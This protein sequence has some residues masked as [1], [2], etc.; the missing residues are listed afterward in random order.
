MATKILKQTGRHLLRD[1]GSC[2][3]E[4]SRMQIIF[5]IHAVGEALAARGRGFEYVAVVPGRSDARIQDL[6]QRCRAAGVPVRSVPRDQLTRLAPYSVRIGTHVVR[7]R[8]AVTVLIMVGS[9]TILTQFYFSKFYSKML[10]LSCI[11]TFSLY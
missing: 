11:A 10:M 3:T 6:V 7:P 9:T 1:K 5:G 2:N 8:K 4:S